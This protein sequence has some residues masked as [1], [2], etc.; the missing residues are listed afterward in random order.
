MEHALLGETDAFGHGGERRATVTALG[1]DVPGGGQDLGASLLGLS[2][3]TQR[4][5]HAEYPK[6][7]TYRVL[8]K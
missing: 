8:G 6:P 3:A 4:T 1:E 2:P 5:G 7:A